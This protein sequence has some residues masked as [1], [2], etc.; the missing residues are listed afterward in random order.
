M[1][2][3]NLGQGLYSI[4]L[5]WDTP[6]SLA[7]QRSY[8]ATVAWRAVID[9]FLINLITLSARKADWQVHCAYR[10]SHDRAAA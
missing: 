2:Y 1:V 8:F 9:L 4:C 5:G 6:S 7:A 10:A 3:L